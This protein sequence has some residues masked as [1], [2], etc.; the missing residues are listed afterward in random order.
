[1]LREDMYWLKLLRVLVKVIPGSLGLGLGIAYNKIL[2]YT[3]IAFTFS[4]LC[5]VF[6]TESFT[7][8]NSFC[9]PRFFVIPDEFSPVPMT[10]LELTEILLSI[11]PQTLL[12]LIPYVLQQKWAIQATLGD[13]FSSL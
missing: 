13:S 10:G 6:G 5:W 7:V 8:E 12:Y 1:M 2:L 9:Y 11:F 4:S 3:L